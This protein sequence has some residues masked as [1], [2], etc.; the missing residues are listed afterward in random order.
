M[1]KKLHMETQLQTALLTSHCYIPR[2]HVVEECHIL[3]NT[4]HKKYHSFFQKENHPH[5]FPTKIINVAHTNFRLEIKHGF[6]MRLHITLM[7]L[8]NVL[9]MEPNTEAK[10]T[11]RVMLKALGGPFTIRVFLLAV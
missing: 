10:T 4:L 7:G 11:K 5:Q 2:A 3:T 1:L 6:G 8:F 9:V